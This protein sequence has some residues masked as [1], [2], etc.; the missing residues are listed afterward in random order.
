MN[1]MA[2]RVSAQLRTLEEDATRRQQL[3]ADVAHELRSPVTTLR[4]MSGALDEGLAD[5]PERRAR[6]VRSMVKTSDRMLHLVTDL[7]ELAKLDLKELPLHLHQVD[8]RELAAAVILTHQA[9]AT[10]ANMTLHPIE[11]GVPVIRTADPDRLA[12][13]LDNL[14][15]N[16]ISYAGPGA[17]LFVLLD[18]NGAG[19]RLIVKDTGQGIPAEHLPYLFDP[20]YRV[21]MART[22]KDNHS[23]LGLRIARGLI[24]A[25]GATLHIESEVGQGTTAIITFPRNNP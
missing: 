16:A 1:E 14:L 10:Q 3:L 12:Q 15:D 24:E 22:P 11:P 25:H 17:E 20:F 19:S 7:L 18:S 21:D 6:A 9:A 2:E 4:T 5:D 23:G 8:L 13:V